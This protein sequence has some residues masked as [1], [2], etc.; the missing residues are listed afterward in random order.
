MNVP[1]PPNLTSTFL[2]LRPDSSIEQMPLDDTFWPRLM[3]GKLGDFHH[4]YLVTT[5]SFHEDWPGWE[6]HPNGDE[7]VCL[8]SG[9]VTFVFE[10]QAGNEEITLGRLGDFVFVP[11]GIWHTARTRVPTVML[12]ITAGEGTQGRPAVPPAVR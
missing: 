10:R 9:A 4:E 6:R 7:I 12:F 2:R 5:S 1:A 8:L 11:Q 3:S